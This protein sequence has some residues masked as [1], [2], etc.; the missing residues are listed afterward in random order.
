M[1]RE[2]EAIL[3]CPVCYGPV[4]TRA[5]Q[6][7]AG[8]LVCY[9]CARGLSHCATCRRPMPA[10]GVRCLVFERLAA[11]LPPRSCGNPGC[12]RVLGIAEAE[13]HA[14][15]CAYQPCVC[16]VHASCTWRG[17]AL[18]LPDHLREAHATVAA[19]PSATPVGSEV[20]VHLTNPS[21]LR[22]DFGWRGLV[23]MGD[24]E[25][26]MLHARTMLARAPS[27][28]HGLYLVF[29]CQSATPAARARTVVR[30][31]VRGAS[32]ASSA[33]GEEHAVTGPCWGACDDAEAIL[34]SS[35]VLRVEIESALRMSGAS[36]RM[37]E[38]DMLGI[39]VDPAQLS[40]RL[41]FAF[42]PEDTTAVERSTT[43]GASVSIQAS[44]EH[45]PTQRVPM[46]AALANEVANGAI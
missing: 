27:R 3:D 20:E 36:Q 37:Y 38:E 39:A 46:Q 41:A 12:D 15:A 2:L 24:D 18:D 1:Q 28:S 10:L 17:R 33:R 6:C 35:S 40:L 23:R 22:Y 9:E 7:P 4:G 45:V 25:W 29:Y 8:H 13:E 11:L 43:A 34:R 5:Y 19:V 32:S 16:P 31:S 26:F 44:V 14:A 30:A 42:L 21:G